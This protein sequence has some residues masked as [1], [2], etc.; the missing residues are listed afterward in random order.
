MRK[1][2]ILAISFLL[3]ACE[4]KKETAAG[5]TEVTLEQA[6]EGL[7]KEGKLVAEI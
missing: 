4:N 7:P 3:L 6:T 5:D 2:F 1:P